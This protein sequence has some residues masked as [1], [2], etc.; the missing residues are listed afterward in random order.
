V[1]VAIVVAVVV[2]VVVVVAV[3]VVVVVVVIVVVSV[4]IVLPVV[5]V[6][7]WIK[8]GT[9]DSNALSDIGEQWTAEVLLNCL[10]VI[11]RF[12]KI[13]SFVELQFLRSRTC[14]L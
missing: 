11:Q 4:V 13:C 14:G 2:V 10:L 6:V 3:V 1:A 12:T 5:I 9:V 7:I 8:D